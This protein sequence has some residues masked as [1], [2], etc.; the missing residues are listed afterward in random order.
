MYLICLDIMRSE[1]I[2]WKVAG[3]RPL[4]LVNYLFQNFFASK[5]FAFDRQVYSRYIRNLRS[6]PMIFCGYF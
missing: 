5:G 1:S 3:H 4:L 6:Y 2:V